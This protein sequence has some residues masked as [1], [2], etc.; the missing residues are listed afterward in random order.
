MTYLAVRA[1]ELSAIFSG[2]STA[3][4]A[5]VKDGL[6]IADVFAHRDQLTSTNS[7]CRSRVRCG[8]G[9][10]SAG[11]QDRNGHLSQLG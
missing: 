1:A 2:L 9:D 5:D 3:F 6:M 8:V 11:D 10:D 7:D 4:Q